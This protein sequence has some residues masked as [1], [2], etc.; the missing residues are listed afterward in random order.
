MSEPVILVIDDEADTIEFIRAVCKRRG[1]R[2]IGALTGR[3]GLALA[4]SERPALI[5]ID[6]LLPEI[7]GFEICRELCADPNT[8]HIPKAV[9]SASVSVEDQRAAA[10]AG[11]DQYLLKPIG[12][13]LLTS[14][15]DA[16]LARSSAHSSD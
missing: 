13:K 10:A 2:V 9:F 12:V 6:L 8:A 5:L 4:R 14:V 3:E 11:A 1:L 15:V 7:N 16:L